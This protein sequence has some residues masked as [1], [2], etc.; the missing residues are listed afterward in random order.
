MAA[1]PLVLHLVRS[2]FAGIG[3]ATAAEA[4]AVR[5]DVSVLEHVSLQ[6]AGLGE[7]LLADGALVGP[8]TLVG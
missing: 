2:Q 3:E 1:T 5:L 8:R 7:A 4:A 6:M